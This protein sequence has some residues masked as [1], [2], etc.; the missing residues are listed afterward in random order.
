MRRLTLDSELISRLRTATVADSAESIYDLLSKAADEIERQ[1]AQISCWEDT[2]RALA[3]KI[4][5]ANRETTNTA[6]E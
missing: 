1:H 4:S 6:N 5:E 2:I 3:R